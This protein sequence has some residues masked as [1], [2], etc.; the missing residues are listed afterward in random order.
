MNRLLVTYCR[1][2]VCL[3]SL[4]VGSAAAQDAAR[5]DIVVADFEG[6][7]YGKWKAEGEAFGEGPA[8]GTLPR[9]MQVSGFN[10]NGL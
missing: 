1:P 8:K 4:L 9:Q 10:G 2:C 6:D 5:P 7:T 3:L